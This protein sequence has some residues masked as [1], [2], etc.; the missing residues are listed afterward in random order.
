M[1]VEIQ[2]TKGYVAVVDDED[3]DLAELNWQA[4]AAKN[5]TVPYAIRYVR[6]EQTKSK[7]TTTF[8]HRTILSR[9]LGRDL[10][11]KEQVDHANGNGMD[12]R[13]I[14]LRIATPSQNGSN[15]KVSVRNKS[16][17]KGVYWNKDMRKWHVQ[18]RVQGERIHIGCFTDLEEAAMAYREAAIKY[19]GEFARW[20]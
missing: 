13:R 12:N 4:F 19:F 17:R 1:T 2:L 14:N 9:M 5:Q 8:M 18:I 6:T 20:E 15:R 10:L 16:G 3:G 7:Q 11:R